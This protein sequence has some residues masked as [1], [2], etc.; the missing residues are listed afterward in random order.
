MTGVIGLKINV[1]GKSQKMIRN[2]E[3]VSNPFCSLDLR[4]E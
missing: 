3:P 1:L 4:K 2:P